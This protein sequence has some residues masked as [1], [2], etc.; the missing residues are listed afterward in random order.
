VALRV[1]SRQPLRFTQSVGARM[2]L[3]CMSSGKVLLAFADDV[4]EQ[5]ARQGELAALTPGTITSPAALLADLRAIRE[6]G[7][8]VNRGE[9]IPGVRGVAAPV[10]ADDGPVT[11]AVAVQG[12][13]IRMSEDS[14][15]ALGALVVATARAV[16]ATIQA[17]C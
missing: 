16:R 12:P 5:V 13:E 10:L 7:Y 6:R 1:D 3:Y 4:P 11:A 9:R 17:G 2:P 15:P 8:S 14:F